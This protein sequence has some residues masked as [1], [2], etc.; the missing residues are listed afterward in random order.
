LPR[1]VAKSGSEDGPDNA[2]GLTLAQAVHTPSFW[3]AVMSCATFGFPMIALLQ[4]QAAHLQ[5]IGVPS[6]F[7]A[8]ALGAVGLMNAA[9]KPAFGFL[10]E[11]MKAKYALS[12]GLA[13]QLMAV[14]IIINL[15]PSSPGALLWVYAVCL[16]LGIGSWAPTMSMLVSTNFGMAAYGTI[17]GT[18]SLINTLGNSL[19][20]LFAGRIFDVT[21]SY[22]P[23]FF[24]FIGFYAVAIVSTLLI[25]KPRIRSNGEVTSG[26]SPAAASLR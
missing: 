17:F 7:A 2:S 12:V 5:D 13:L 11:S 14:V 9:G 19:G 22:R 15:T 16:G 3:L 1:L 23:A 8:G 24:T 10:T 25:R 26:G 21:G 4:N 6:L 18:I 20:P